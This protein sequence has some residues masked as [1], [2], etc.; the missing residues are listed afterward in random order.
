MAYAPQDRGIECSPEG[1][2]WVASSDVV[3]F[4]ALS[5]VNFSPPVVG[6]SGMVTAGGG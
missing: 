3:Q 6:G 2:A 5:V 1:F 4:P